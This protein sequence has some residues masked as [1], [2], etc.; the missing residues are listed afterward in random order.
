VLLRA[1]R[2]SRRPSRRGLSHL[3]IIIGLRNRGRAQRPRRSAPSSSKPRP[4]HIE[5]RD[6]NFDFGRG[7]SGNQG[8]VAGSHET[9]RHG[10]LCASFYY[11]IGV[12][13]Y[14]AMAGFLLGGGSGFL[15]GVLIGQS[16]FA[17]QT[18]YPYIVAF[19]T[20]PKVAVAPI[21]LIWFGYGLS[22]KVV[23][24]ATISF[25]PL[26]ANTIA[27]M[28][29]TPAEEQELFRAFMASRWHMFLRL[30]MP[31][32]LPFVFVGIDMSILLSVTGA[33][34]GRVCRCP[35]GPGFPHL[36]AKSRSQHSRDFCHFDGAWS[37]RPG[38]PSDRPFASAQARVL[39][40]AASRRLRRRLIGIE[41]VSG[42]MRPLSERRKSRCSR[43]SQMYQSFPS[44][45]I[46]S[47]VRLAMI[48]L[49]QDLLRRVG[50]EHGEV[51]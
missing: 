40:D 25:F 23:I 26:L 43:S 48:T 41:P 9:R 2:Y 21:V 37:D 7:L 22:S 38:A 3:T 15:L 32:A 28:R 45:L 27:G 14:E 20:L 16:R 51:N 30:Q 49:R 31:R 44:D 18:L 42:A 12:T 5:R 10:R 33:L 6:Q 47:S 46:A 29:A 13:L 1:L 19:Q 11:H 34:V 50:A 24:T 36:A 17:E 39:D 35:R 8:T 4:C